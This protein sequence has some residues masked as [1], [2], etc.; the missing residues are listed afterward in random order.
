M[1]W[2]EIFFLVIKGKTSSIVFYCIP[3]GFKLVIYQGGTSLKNE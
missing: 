1:T 3:L 2:T